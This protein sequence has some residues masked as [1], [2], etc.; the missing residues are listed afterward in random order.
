MKHTIIRVYI[1][2]YVSV[3]LFIYLSVYTLVNV[4]TYVTY[5]CSLRGC[6]SNDTTVRGKCKHIQ[7]LNLG[8]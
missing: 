5:V 3:N 4:L 1:Y 7:H 2:I 8:L 6:G